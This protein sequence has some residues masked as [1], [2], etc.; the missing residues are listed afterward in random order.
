MRDADDNL[1]ADLCA[2][3]KQFAREI[4]KRGEANGGD[5]GWAALAQAIDEAWTEAETEDVV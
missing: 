3:F 2:E 1:G 4:V 5:P